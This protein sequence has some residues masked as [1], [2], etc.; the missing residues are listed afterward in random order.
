M[1]RVHPP[2]ISGRH[3]PFPL[4]ARHQACGE[5]ENVLP[6]AHPHFVRLPIATRKRTH[7]RLSTLRSHYLS[8]ARHFGILQGM[9]I[10][11][12][13]MNVHPGEDLASVR[14]AIEAV[15]IPVFRA[16]ERHT[17]AVLGLRLGA[18][19]AAELREPKCIQRF[20]DFLQRHHLSVIGIN[21]FPHGDFHAHAVKRAA[22]EPDW[23]NFQRLAYTRDLFYALTHLPIADFREGHAASVTTVPLAYNHGQSVDDY[24]E[25]ICDVALFLRKLEGFT[26]IHMRLALEP[27]PDCLLEATQD[28]IDFFERL[29]SHPMWNPLCKDNIGLCF[30]TCHY[31]VNF[32]DPLKALKRLVE[33][34]I[35]IARIQLSAAVE[36]S[37]Q[38]QV[39]ELL[40]FLDASYMHQT[41]IQTPEG[42]I[43]YHADFTPDILQHITGNVARIHYHVP[44]TW[45]GTG[46]L[47]STRETLTPAFWRYVRAGGWP[48]EVETYAYFVSPDFLRAHTLSEALL[49]DIK[50]CLDQLHHA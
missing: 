10:V 35:P 44:L 38:A 8:D 21:G 22:Y 25:M 34:S 24:L 19:A 30:D 37:P 32:E 42:Q 29:W 23:K 39:N 3:T 31:A 7:L 28:T 48:I 4:N 11:T 50:W 46:T 26:G 47:H 2:H 20:A 9:N 36:T 12:Y 18:R 15:S 41:R 14:N 27:E 6:Y 5:E 13:C 1:N 40:P 49:K 43:H 45:E 16:L 17:P 33:Y